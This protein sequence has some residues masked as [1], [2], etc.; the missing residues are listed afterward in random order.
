MVEGKFAFV[1]RIADEF[2]SEQ[3]EKHKFQFCFHHFYR[4]INAK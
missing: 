3:Y 1:F 4:P 2:I